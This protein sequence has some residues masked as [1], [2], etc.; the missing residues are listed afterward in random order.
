MSHRDLI[1]MLRVLLGFGL[2]Y[3]IGFERG[4]RGSP[5]GDRTYALV[6]LAAAAVTAVTERLSPQAIA[7]VVTGVGFIGAA[8]VFRQAVNHIRGMTSAATILAVTAVGVVA[9]TGHWLLAVLV[10]A[11]ILVD[12]ELR[13]IPLLRFFDAATHRGHAVDDMFRP[14]DDAPGSPPRV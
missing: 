10:T 13:N 8:L 2:A 7:G 14:E 12:L 11:L 9:G 3:A 6:G 4:I 5:A 1:L